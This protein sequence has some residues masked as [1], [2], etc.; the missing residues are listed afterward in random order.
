M[1]SRPRPSRACGRHTLFIVLL[2]TIA[3]PLAA[4]LTTIPPT[5][6]EIRI[7]GVLDETAWQ[8][9]AS[10]Q[11]PYEYFPGD[12]V[13]APVETTMFITFD[14]SRL[15]FAFDCKDPD[16][17][18]IRAHLMD[19]DDIQPFVQ[20]DHVGLLLDTFNDERRAIQ[21]R[22]N[23]LGVQADAVFSELEGF[24]DFSWD[25]IWDASG[26]I[27]DTGYVVEIAI[28]FNQLRFP[29]GQE[30]LT[31]GIQGSR[32]YPRSVRHRISNNRQERDR[33]CILCQMHKFSGFEGISPGKNIEVGPSVTATRADV[34]SD[35]PTGD[36]EAGDFDFRPSVNGRWGITPNVILNGTIN[37]D[38]SQVEA[39]ELQVDVNQRFA[40]FFEEKRPFFLEGADF[41]LT[42]LQA[43]FT[44]TVVDPIAGAKL[45]G[46]AGRNAIGVFAARDRV[47]NLLIPSN[48]GTESAFL[49]DDVAGGV[50]R[51]R[52][53]IGPGSTVGGL[54]TGRSSDGYQNAV[55]GV[56]GFLRLSNTATVDFQYLRSATEYPGSLDLG[57]AG[58]PGGLSSDPVGG[59][60]NVTFQYG[61]DK[62]DASAEYLDLSPGFRGDFG[63]FQ[64]TDLRDGEIEVNRLFRGNSSRWYSLI[65]VGGAVA[66][67]G[68]YEGN[69]TDQT[70][71]ASAFY[72]GRLQSLVFVSASR[73]KEFFD[74]VSFDLNEY[75]LFGQI[76]P[77][78]NLSLQLHAQIGDAP[79]VRELRKVDLLSI[80]PGIGLK[81]GRG[82][83]LTADAT[84]YRLSDEDGRILLQSIA[85]GQLRY[86]FN[87]RSFVRFIAQ[88]RDV[89]TANPADGQSRLNTQA[90]FSYKLNPQT[91][92]FL[93]YSDGWRGGPFS[94]TASERKFFF[95]IGYAFVA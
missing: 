43:V 59:A 27:T 40:L 2:L 5:D 64:R 58:D 50:V 20:D 85:Q 70:V 82:L 93:G 54:F 87:V 19:R 69:L 65:A 22:V 31:W 75:G 48:R 6:S 21:L 62:W 18:S 23:P 68:D 73:T 7:D 72:R 88:Y 41:F 60:G 86:S 94:L 78:G 29:D 12:N 56:D 76:Q 52:R 77:T 81:L 1:I 25:I 39:D 46:K 10:V 80:S 66:R 37:P 83:R 3:H 36:F 53:D 67:A 89:N 61:S 71:E 91:V 13:E 35:F 55:G 92:L 38:F 33:N 51:Y 49:E 74:D 26:R 9:A 47:N 45:T 8:R 95:K 17:S 42:P 28:P 14:Q 11:L 79:F 57:D 16:P 44:R 90:L 15:Y 24:E 34:R 63:F 4:Q 30:T 32:S 84:S